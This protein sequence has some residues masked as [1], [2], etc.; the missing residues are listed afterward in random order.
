M[1]IAS[2]LFDSSS[3]GRRL[4][5]SARARSHVASMKKSD[6]YPD[7]DAYGVPQ[8]AVPA[9]GHPHAVVGG[10]NTTVVYLPPQPYASEPPPPPQPSSVPTGLPVHADRPAYLGA[11]QGHGQQVMTCPGCGH[12]GPSDVVRVSGASTCFA[13]ILTFGL[14]LC[15]C[16]SSFKDTYHHCAN[17][18]RV[19]A[20][21]KMA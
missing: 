16:P 12:S 5:V 2:S 13:A 7:T 6:Y 1:Y 14:S 8:T 21:A 9:Q 17:C 11:T 20:L 4:V 10:P 18:S 3:R 15:C 19:L